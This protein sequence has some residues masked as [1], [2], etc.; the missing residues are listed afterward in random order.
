[1]AKTEPHNKT[2]QTYSHTGT[3]KPV[4]AMISNYYNIDSQVSCEQVIKLKIT[5]INKMQGVEKTAN[6]V[7]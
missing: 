1:V 3:K 7:I 4:A 5:T 6:L 2:H